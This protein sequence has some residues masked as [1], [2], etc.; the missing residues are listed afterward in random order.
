MGTCCLGFPFEETSSSAESRGSKAELSSVSTDKTGA[1]GGHGSDDW[2]V[3]DTR[4]FLGTLIQENTG[5]SLKKIHAN[6]LTFLLSKG[7]V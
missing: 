1:N 2:V 4:E 5:W 6:F 3:S 7:G